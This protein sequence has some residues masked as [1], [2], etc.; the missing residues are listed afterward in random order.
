M[1]QKQIRLN[2]INGLKDIVLAE[3]GDYPSFS[4]QKTS[5]DTIDLEYRSDF[6]KLR[7]LRSVLRVSLVLADESFTPLHLN[8][9]KSLIG[10]LVKELLAE[11]PDQ[12]ET[13][14]LSCAGADSPEVRAIAAYIADTFHLSESDD[15]ADLKLRIV[16]NDGLW[17]LIIEITPLPLSQRSYKM[18]DMDAAMN[19]TIAYAMNQLLGL[20]AGLDYLN[21]FSGSATLPI[22]AAL[23]CPGLGRLAGIEREREHVALAIRNIRAAGLLGR[24]KLEVADIFEEPQLGLFDRIVADLPFG[25]NNARG[26]D[27]AALYKQFAD[28]SAK[29]LKSGGRLAAYSSE[30]ELLKSSLIAAGFKIDKELALRLVTN[31]GR[32]LVVKMFVCGRG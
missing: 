13:F 15:E 25:L 21:I 9:H 19:P 30:H 5:E 23:A 1:T 4:V 12:F 16:K 29:C 20:E 31:T 3:L 10:D 24:I 27:L 11:S 7:E 32:G 8:R 18:G 2:F 17:E 14:R 6:G 22:E 26:E 28:Y